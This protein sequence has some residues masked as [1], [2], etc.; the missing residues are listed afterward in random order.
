MQWRVGENSVARSGPLLTGVLLVLGAVW[1]ALFVVRIHAHQANVDDF[2]YASVARGLVQSPNPISAVLHTGQNSPLVLVLAAPGVDLFGVYGGLL[3]NLPLLL[4]L[5]TGAFVLARRWLTPLGAALTALGVGLN[6]AVLGYSVMFNFALAS[7]TAVVWCIAAYV[8]SER[9]S[10]MRWSIGFGVA[11]AALILSRSIAPVYAIPLL[12]IV[13]IDLVLGVRRLDVL[14]RRPVLAAA[15]TILV[16]AGPWWVVSGPALWHYLTYAGYQ[17]SSGFTNGG[18]SLTPAAVVDRVNHE[19]LNLG[20]A[21]SVAL[22]LMVVATVWQTV[23]DRRARQL[24]Q[25]WVP[26]A[27]VVAT[28]LILSSSSN[29]GTAFGLPLIAV[30][31]VVCAVVLGRTIDVGTRQLPALAT[32]LVVLLLAGAASQFTISTNRWWPTTPYRMEALTAGASA[33]TN[34]DALTASVAHSL[35]KGIAIAAAEGPSMNGNGLGWYARTGTDINVPTG[36]SST[37]SAISL[38]RSASSLITDSGDAAFNPF[39]NQVTLEKAAN[40]AGYRATRVWKPSKGQDVVLWT[41][42]SK[43]QVVFPPPVVVIRRPGDGATIKGTTY[44]FAAVSDPLGLVHVTFEVRGSTLAHP[45]TMAA[46]PLLY[47]WFSGFNADQLPTGTYA[48]TCVAE[49][50]DGADGS[51]TITV[52]VSN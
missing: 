45:L 23:W 9:F 31:I 26:A 48:V 1:I 18:A 16:L 3:V 43:S 20:W 8:R 4:L 32:V 37:R 52:H 7:T 24:G 47:G 17:G 40:R 19:L 39:L 12:A 34:I 29:S 50:V 36:E 15:A 5:G 11:F 22:G 13:L 28:L 30:T 10:S 35:P 41:K 33:R 25:L 42:G 2:L 51:D 6:A 27:W 14:W 46:T 44:L 49:S 38:L 21:E